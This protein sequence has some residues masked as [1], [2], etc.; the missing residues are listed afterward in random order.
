MLDIIQNNPYRLLGIYSNSPIKERVANHNRLKAF[1]KVGKEVSFPLDLSGVL[2]TMTRTTEKVSD[3]EAKLTLSNEQLRYAQFWFVKVTPLDD[4]AIN[5]LIV[6]NIDGAIS[7]LEKK[8]NVSSL[9]NRI[10]CA[11]VTDNYA[12]AIACAY[13]LYSSYTTD[14][15]HIVLGNYQM[16]DTGKL[17]YDF[18]DVLCSAIGAQKLLPYLSDN[19]WKQYISD[20]AIKPLIE[21]L[22]SAI[23]IAK[24]SNGKGTTARYNA[25]AKLMNV[26]KD[27]LSQLKGLLSVADLQYQ[28]IADKIAQEILQCGIDYFN[29]TEED[30]APQK[31]GI[32]QNYALS[33]A[34]GRLVKD[35]C[36][37][38]VDI[39][40]KIGKEYIVRKELEQLTAYIKDLRGEGTSKDSLFA[41]LRLS[42][43]GRTISDIRQIVDESIPLLNTMKTKLGN[44]NVL[45]M[46]ISSAVVSSAINALVEIVNRQQTLSWDK[47]EL[48]SVI[49][50]AVALM[51][52][53]RNMNMDAKT[54]GY[55][56][57]NKSTLDNI[58]NQLNP[59]EGCYI[60]TMVY[61]D[62]NHPQVLILRS[63]RNKYLATRN[64]GR[65]FIKSYYK[66]SPI[67][68]EK[69]KSHQRVNLVIRKLLDCFV[70]QLKKYN[71]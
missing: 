51:S 37:E 69:L 40:R 50:D 52:L 31:A 42:G 29:A 47:N 62:Y 30:D 19:D 22:Q 10:V 28:M 14:F 53:L 59:S 49:R 8:E 32:L 35:R 61:G 12:L 64:W 20:Q 2:S 44:T 55:Y 21:T 54:R 27:E 45:Y 41:A 24:A 36:K 60:A 15:V 66:Y 4:V 65:A 25:G 70:V 46:N 3:A 9:Q 18:L 6:G 5:H 68:V 48:R 11:L 43:I 56:N 16:I 26:A 33:I 39:L 57:G 23:D 67:L 63:F 71:Y 1:L 7:I 58:N 13:K 38:N 17:A 34:V